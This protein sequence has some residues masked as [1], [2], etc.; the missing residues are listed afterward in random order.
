MIFVIN[1]FIIGLTELKYLK[2]EA[3]SDLPWLPSCSGV[4]S[5]HATSVSSDSSVDQLSKRVLTCNIFL[6]SGRSLS[7]ALE[8]IKA[9]VGF[10]GFVELLQTQQAG[11]NVDLQ[12]FLGLLNTDA[13]LAMIEE[14]KTNDAFLVFRDH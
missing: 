7:T 4:S 5:N 11:G 14:L 1:V 3:C 13:F 9:M 6:F 8:E 2:H 12:E 10:D